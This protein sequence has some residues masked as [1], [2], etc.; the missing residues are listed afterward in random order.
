MKVI[1]VGDI[2]VD[3]KTMEEQAKRLNV[4]EEITVVSFNW[5]NTSKSVFRQRAHH[6]ELKGPEAEEI[7]EALYE[8][9][10]D[11]DMILTHFCPIPAKLI[12]KAE[13]LKLIGTCRTG[14]EHIDVEAASKKNIPVVHCIRNAMPVADFVLG[15]IISETRNIARGN[16]SLIEGQWGKEFPNSQFT[17]TLDQLKV[18]ILGVGYIGKLVA[19]KLNALGVEVLGTDTFV[20]QEELLEEGLKIK[21]VDIQELFKT[22]DVISLHLRLNEHTKNIID[23]KLLSLMKPNS[24]IINTSRAG[25]IVEMDLLE[26]LKNKKIAGA[27]IDVWWEEPIPKDSEFLKLDNLTATPHIAGETIDAIPMSPKLMIKEINQFLL[28]GKNS[29]VVNLNNISVK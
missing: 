20:T 28:T 13:R 12:E 2:Y 17:T 4:K 29:M 25:V 6:I 11:A 24:Y 7:P 22:C 19:G 26:V 15:L 9:I 14:M 10:K 8:E 23:K 21:M 5:E 18:G 1:V 27:A 3:P 16:R